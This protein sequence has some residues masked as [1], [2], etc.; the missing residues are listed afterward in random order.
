M[1][2]CCAVGVVGVLAD[3]LYFCSGVVGGRSLCFFVL[4]VFLGVVGGRSRSAF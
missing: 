4:I 1:P 2:A 3:V